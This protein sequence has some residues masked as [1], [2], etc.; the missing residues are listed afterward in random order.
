M[1][2]AISRDVGGLRWGVVMSVGIR[3]GAGDG[4]GAAAPGRM[5][6]ETVAQLRRPLGVL[7]FAGRVTSL[8]LA[9][10]RAATSSSTRRSSF[11]FQ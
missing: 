5:G 11:H 7:P 1:G 9:V 2:Q 10:G 8:A 3:V 4:V 6:G